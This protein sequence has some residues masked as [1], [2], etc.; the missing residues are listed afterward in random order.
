MQQIDLGDEET[1]ESNMTQTEA[2]EGGSEVSQNIWERDTRTF[3]Y[4]HER[5][6]RYPCV[7]RTASGKLLVLFTRQTEAQ[8]N[9]GSGELL[10]VP[11]S[12]DGKWWMRPKVVFRGQEG[13]PRAVG[14]MTTLSSGRIVAPF[15]LLTEGGTHSDLG[16]L[17]SE[18]EG[19]SW[20]VRQG[21]SCA[22]LVW[23]MPGG[24]PFEL[25]GALVMPVFGA[26]CPGELEATRH[27]CGLLRSS[28]EGESWGD[29]SLIASDST[30]SF[31]FEYP[32]V[33]P[34]S[35]GSLVAI[36]TAR[37]LE[38][39]IDAPQV[40]MRCFSRDGGRSW[41]EPEQFCVGSW[42]CL[43]A[44]DEH[45]TICA[46]T[47]WCGW[48]EMR[49]LVSYD[50][51]HTFKQDQPFVK[52]GWVCFSEPS[53]GEEPIPIT[54][55]EQ[56]RCCWAYQPLPLPPVVPYLAGDWHVGHW[57]FPTALALSGDRFMVLLGN[58]QRGNVY[59]DPP[60]E[61]EIPMEQERIEAI[62]F[63]RLATPEN[64]PPRFARTPRRDRWEMAESWTPQQ[65]AERTN[66]PPEDGVALKSGRWVK[67]DLEIREDNWE[68]LGGLKMIGNERGYWVSTQFADY[69]GEVVYRAVP[70]PKYSDDQGQTW[71]EAELTDMGPLAT[72]AFPAGPIVELADGTL[73]AP[74]Y[75]MRN[76]EDMAY[77]HCAAAL[78]RSRD[79]GK[80]WGDWSVVAY[81][82]QE[83]GTLYFTETVVLPLPSGTWVAFMR[84]EA[85]TNVPYTGISKRAV[86][87]DQGYTWSAPE[88]C[89]PGSQMAG[90]VLPDGG[91]AVVVRTH[92]RQSCGIYFSYDQGNTWD[93]ALA[94]PY[95]T[96]R[97]GLLDEDHF[98]VYAGN[99]VVIYRR[100]PVAA[101]W[102]QAER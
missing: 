98:W 2:A 48:G 44:I 64:A 71:L 42:P 49:L 52:H 91:M 43:A 47:I 81:D 80:T 23:G 17:S 83:Q 31:S 10:V 68:E 100:V 79:G 8:E 7:T 19:R 22:P 26:L 40:L 59:I 5:R 84:T 36:L 96:S 54:D 13:E 75:G 77:Y 1:R 18:D 65:W 85:H 58:R 87:T 56:Y 9:E 93:Y 73:V 37:K 41:T 61:Q 74:C 101:E 3:V 20:S 89:F 55:I 24:R 16:L 45:T 76:E 34:L 82:D 29:W 21:L 25:E 32:A 69:P 6:A 88:I 38:V 95:N 102:T 11:R 62:T 63:E 94:G 50:G 86:S 15:A 35:D 60:R 51:F 12:A 67:M 99:E 4:L 14:T 46:Y 97:A 39:G 30:G 70:R 57:G 33:L 90:L 27:C 92:G 66:L 72:S 28:D 78:C 53:P